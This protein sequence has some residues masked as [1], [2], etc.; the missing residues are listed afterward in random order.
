MT[1]AEATRS[2]K[3]MRR[4]GWAL[5]AGWVIIDEFGA[6]IWENEIVNSRPL[7]FIADPNDVTAEDWEVRG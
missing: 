2:G 7:D 4:S 5:S 3:P 1:M 6:Y